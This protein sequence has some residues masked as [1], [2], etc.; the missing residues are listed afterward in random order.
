LFYALVDGLRS[1]RVFQG[2]GEM[3]NLLAGAAARWPA[4]PRRLPARPSA[5]TRTCVYRDAQFEVLLLNWAPG[6]ISAIHDHG[7]QRCWMTVLEGCLEVE[8]YVRLDS[9]EV[10]GYARVEP[11]ESRMLQGGEIDTRSGRFD[12]HRVGASL[13]APAV[14]L[15]VYRGPLQ[16]FLI[17]DELSRRCE[18]AI[19]TYDDILSLEAVASS[20]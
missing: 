1:A 10:P 19:G 18:T 7:G 12:L 5:Y 9:G 2:D 15:H 13:E 3:L 4:A 8:D 20:H 14:S 17:Y 6:S 11:R 16:R